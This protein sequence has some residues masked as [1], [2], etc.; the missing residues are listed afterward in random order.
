MSAQLKRILIIAIAFVL[1]AWLLLTLSRHMYFSP[2]Q[3][4]L[5]KV[6]QLTDRLLDRQSKNP[7]VMKR[8]LQTFAD[9]TLG[10]SRETVDHA[11]RT[12]LNRMTEELG[13][14]DASVGTSNATVRMSPARRIFASN[15]L[16]G[17]LRDQPDFIELEAWV[18]AK[19]SLEQV[20]TLIDRIEAASWLKRI[21]KVRMQAEDG[22]KRCAINVRLTT[23]LLP[24]LQPSSAP[25]LEPYDRE[26]LKQ[27]AGLIESNPFALPAPPAPA[28]EQPVQVATQ[29]PSPP[30][31]P[32]EQWALSGVALGPEGDE[33][34]LR[35]ASTGET[36][37][38]M[39]GESIG[40]AILLAAQ[41]EVARFE[42]N[43]KQFLVT[44]G[45]K[46]S[47]QT[48]VAP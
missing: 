48:V 12:Q 2:R 44:V 27:Y 14:S 10:S 31:F 21:D 1:G 35:R 13:L 16:Q 20:L 4:K 33:A 7:V 46:L 29:P 42:L 28:P 24:D 15:G 47:E 39:V 37:R 19:G 17:E 8:A 43:Q 25:A 45:D 26:R 22:G 40:D 5:A 30:K 6:D 36:L 23:V 32:Y 11:L 9:R 18:N 41:G 38:L 3:E 34:W